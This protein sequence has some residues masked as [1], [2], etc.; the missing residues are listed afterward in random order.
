V[1][2]LLGLLVLALESAQ[3]SLK[4][5]DQQKFQNTTKKQ[6]FKTFRVTTIV[7]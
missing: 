4:E 3:V 2:D 6:K 5:K 1:N 7:N